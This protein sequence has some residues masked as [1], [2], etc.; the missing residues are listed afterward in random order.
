LLEKVLQTEI[1]F[2]QIVWTENL[3]I[4]QANYVHYLQSSVGD[5]YE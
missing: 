1:R 4:S 5:A 3:T 2:E